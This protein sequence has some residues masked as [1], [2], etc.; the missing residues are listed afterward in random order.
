MIEVHLLPH[1]TEDKKIRDGEGEEDV[2]FCLYPTLLLSRER[3]SGAKCHMTI[4]GQSVIC[5]SVQ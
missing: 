4:M 2:R 5:Q 3:F 1:L